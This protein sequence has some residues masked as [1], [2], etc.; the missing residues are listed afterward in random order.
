MSL[1]LRSETLRLRANQ[2]SRYFNILHVL[3]VA[4]FNVFKHVQVVVVLFIVFK[5][6][7]D[8]LTLGFMNIDLF[9]DPYIKNAC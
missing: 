1:K 9:L 4:L 7:Q 2:V 6:V 8:T 3:V 5:H